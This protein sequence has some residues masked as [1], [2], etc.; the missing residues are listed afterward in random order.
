MSVSPSLVDRWSRALH[1][2]ARPYLTVFITTLYNVICV[3]ALVEG[4]LKIIEYIAAI[5]P[6][7]SLVLGFYF[8]ER[9]ALKIP[10]KDDT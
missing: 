7:N 10:G 5:G 3:W 9:A 4:E 2:L 8:G 6:T 1:S